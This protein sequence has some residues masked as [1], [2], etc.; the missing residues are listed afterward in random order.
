[1]LDVKYAVKKAKSYVIDLFEEESIRDLGL[2]EV[3]YDGDEQTWLI[4]LGFS[5]P[6][7]TPKVNSLA[8]ALT[9][10]ENVESKPK[11]RA[12]KIIKINDSSGEVLSIKQIDYQK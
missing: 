5:R 8:A 4:T 6:W 12:Y 10:V 3:E 2:E 7:D 9:G 11:R 1:M